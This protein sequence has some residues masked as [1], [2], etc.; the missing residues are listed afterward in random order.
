[1]NA[2]KLFNG[3]PQATVSPI[4]RRRLRLAVKRKIQ[5][6]NSMENYGQHTTVR[7][8]YRHHVLL[9]DSIRPASFAAEHRS[10]YG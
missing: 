7:I 1:M 2:R 8:A 10:H 5:P 3:K 6:I 4:A 9:C